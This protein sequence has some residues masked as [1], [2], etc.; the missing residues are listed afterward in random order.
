[1]KTEFNFNFG[2]SHSRI[3]ILDEIPSICDYT[4][5]KALIVCDTNT[6]SFARTISNDRIIPLLVLEDGEKSKNWASVEKIL[7]A[8]LDAELDRGGL[9]I[10]VGGGVICDLTSFAASIYFRGARLFLV[11]T[12][13]LGM[14]DAGFGGKTGIDLFGLK[15]LAG[16]FFPA[17]LVIM[18]LSSLNSLPEIEWKSGKAELIKTA[19][20]D[21][22]DTLESV[23]ELLKLE[24]SGRTTVAF[25]N[26]LKKCISKSVL[27]K[28]SIVEMDPFESKDSFKTKDAWMKKRAILNLGHTFGHALEAVAVPGAITHGEAVAWG[29]ARACELGLKLGI[30]PQDKACEIAEILS[31]SSFEIKTPHPM[32]KSATTNDP[33]NNP[34]IKAIKAD[35]KRL[36]NK[37]NFIVPGRESAEIISMENIPDFLYEILNGK[38]SI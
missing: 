7:K 4:D 10:G 33:L 20:L 2:N 24:P 9:F 36:N 38:N 11:C 21:S 14:V 19:I 15:N 25:C 13:L 18:P 23:K 8:G 30:T 32:V 26:I 28:G 31:F 6:V 27:F 1:M 17:E 3:L 35:K 16:T 12:T 37:F 22:R 34:I 29:M 5:S